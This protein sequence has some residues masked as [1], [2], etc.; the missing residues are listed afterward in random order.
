MEKVYDRLS[1]KAS[2]LE[3]PLEEIRTLRAEKW[4]EEK[5]EER[6]F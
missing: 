3:E 4:G 6:H 1:T 5:K 2:Q